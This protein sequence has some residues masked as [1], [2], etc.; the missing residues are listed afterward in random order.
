MLKIAPVSAIEP[1]QWIVINCDHFGNHP[2]DLQWLVLLKGKFLISDYFG[3]FIIFMDPSVCQLNARIVARKTVIGTWWNIK[4]NSLS[5][6]CHFGLKLGVLQKKSC[7]A[8]HPCHHSL[9]PSKNSQTR[10][11][12]LISP[13]LAVLLFTS[14]RWLT[15]TPMIF[16]VSRSPNSANRKEKPSVFCF[17]LGNYYVLYVCFLT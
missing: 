7:A 4:I 1:I 11:S 8:Q 13:M 5:L 6:R 12:G 15:K 14:M 16:R 2:I 3:Y 9:T 17:E 10:E